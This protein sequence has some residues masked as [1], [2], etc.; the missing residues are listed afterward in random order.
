M[1]QF[2]LSDKKWLSCVL[3]YTDVNE[4]PEDADDFYC[5]Y[6]NPQLYQVQDDGVTWMI[7]PESHSNVPFTTKDIAANLTAHDDIRSAI[8]PTQTDENSGSQFPSDASDGEYFYRT[9]YKPVTLWRYNE[10]TASWTQFDYG[11][12][13][14]WTG[15]NIEM[16]NFIN[17]PDAVSIQDIV[18]PNIVYR[19][20]VNNR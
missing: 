15:G 5:F 11:G 6:T 8:P 12:R 19:K 14:P 1:Y 16:T 9:D 20:R 17:S 4:V 13:L 3:P 18:K 7:P 2:Y 10:S